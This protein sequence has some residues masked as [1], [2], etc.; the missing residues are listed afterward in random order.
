MLIAAIWTVGS[1][2][3]VGFN[4]ACSKVSGNAEDPYRD[5]GNG[6]FQPAR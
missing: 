3:V 5:E 2:A 1:L 4:Y 6:T